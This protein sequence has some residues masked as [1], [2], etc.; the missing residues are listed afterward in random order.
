MCLHFAGSISV[1]RQ[2]LSKNNSFWLW[3]ASKFDQRR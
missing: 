1:G 3:A 2:V